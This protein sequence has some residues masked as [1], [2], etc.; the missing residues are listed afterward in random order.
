MQVD[1]C[2]RRGACWSYLALERK[3]PAMAGLINEFVELLFS[4]A[5]LQAHPFYQVTV[6]WRF[7]L[8]YGDLAKR[9]AWI[10]PLLMAAFLI[11][12]NK[13]QFP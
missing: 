8:V 4:N 3:S 6:K 12:K 5:G 13:A 7:W 1:A 10:D 2:A 11:S 9:G